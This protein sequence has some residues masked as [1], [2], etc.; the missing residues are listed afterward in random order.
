M[1]VQ[2]PFGSGIFTLY[3]IFLSLRR[4]VLHDRAEG[5]VDRVV[6]RKG[7]ADIGRQQ[8]EVRAGSVLVEVLAAHPALKPTAPPASYVMTYRILCWRQHNMRENRTYGSGGRPN[9]IGRPYPYHCGSPRLETEDPP[10]SK[11]NAVGTPLSTRAGSGR[12][13]VCALRLGAITNRPPIPFLRW[14]R[15]SGTGAV[16][17]RFSMARRPS[18]RRHGRCR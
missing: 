7:G 1:K 10:H 8:H 5:L 11:C 18:A 6:G 3:L 2:V 14:A 15:L 17:G 4:S 12:G 13:V 9:P 16:A